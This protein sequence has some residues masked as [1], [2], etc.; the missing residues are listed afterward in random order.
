[1]AYPSETGSNHGA[2]NQQTG[3]QSF[4]NLMSGGALNGKKRLECRTQTIQVHKTKP[5]DEHFALH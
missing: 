4:P 2:L 5:E 1:M 3:N